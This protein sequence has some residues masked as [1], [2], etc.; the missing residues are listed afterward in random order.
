MNSIRFARHFSQ[1]LGRRSCTVITQNASRIG[2]KIKPEIRLI[3][4]GEN[5][6]MSKRFMSLA[7]KKQRENVADNTGHLGESEI[8]LMLRRKRCL[9]AYLSMSFL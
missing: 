7:A 8:K 6:H 9:F 2:V 1:T 4:L 5:I 3:S